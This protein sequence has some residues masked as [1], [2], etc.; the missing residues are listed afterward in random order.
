MPG[1]NVLVVTTGIVNGNAIKR[2]QL[3]C[4]KPVMGILRTD[5]P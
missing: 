2:N 3:G 4:P 5:A 1:E